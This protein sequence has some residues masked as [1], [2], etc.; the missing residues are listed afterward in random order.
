M[1]ASAKSSTS[2]MRTYRR[3]MELSRRWPRDPDKNEN[4]DLA[5]AIR[6]RIQLAFPSDKPDV[7]IVFL[8]VLFLTK[9]IFCR[10]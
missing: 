9:I 8:L 7:Y 3:F 1:A 5:V 10:R 2:A 4:R 6:K